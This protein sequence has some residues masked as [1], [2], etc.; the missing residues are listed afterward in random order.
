MDQSI[1]GRVPSAWIQRHGG[2]TD[3]R[4]RH[5]DRAVT[6]ALVA[7]LAIVVM[8]APAG[9]AM[10]TMASRATRAAVTARSTWRERGSVEPP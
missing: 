8:A 1:V 2:S 10:T 4:S 5:V 3:P 6:A 7:L 9:A